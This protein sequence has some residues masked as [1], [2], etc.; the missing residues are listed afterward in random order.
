M[1]KDDGTGWERAQCS[2][3]HGSEPNDCCDQSCQ[4]RPTS[5][6]CTDMTQASHDACPHL[7]DDAWAAAELHGFCNAGVCQ[8]CSGFAPAGEQGNDNA[9]AQ[10]DLRDD[11]VKNGDYQEES[12]LA[13]VIRVC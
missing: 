3:M 4:M 9:V 6:I 10:A 5:H 2:F 8:P 7:P 1:A 12:V 13:R 11:I